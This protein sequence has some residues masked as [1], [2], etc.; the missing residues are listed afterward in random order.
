MDDLHPNLFLTAKALS[1]MFPGLKDLGDGFIV[2]FAHHFIEYASVLRLWDVIRVVRR[3]NNVVDK[4]T[5]RFT[6]KPTKF[7]FQCRERMTSV[8]SFS[9]DVDY[10][11]QNRKSMNDSLCV[12]KY[13]EYESVPVITYLVEIDGTDAQLLIAR[14]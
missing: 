6:F 7:R 1:S 13:I 10:D 4:W 3:E 5:V 2:D 11:V 9:I 14:S 12:L 8:T